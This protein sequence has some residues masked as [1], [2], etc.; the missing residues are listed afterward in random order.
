MATAQEVTYQLSAK[1]QEQLGFVQGT[2]FY[3]PFPF[4]GMNVSASA[5]AID[6]KE[7]RFLEN[8]IR[9]GDGNFRTAWDIGAAVYTSPTAGNLLCFFWFNI[10]AVTYCAIFFKDGTAIQLN[11]ATG[12]VTTI[13]SVVGTF[14]TSGSP[15]P[16]CCQSG[17][18]YL[19]IANNITQNSYWIWDGSVLY[20]AGSISPKITIN[21]GGNGYSSI[22][23]VTAFG[24]RGSGLTVTPVIS[25]GSVVA[26]NVTNPGTGYLPGDFVQFAF[27]GGGSDTSAI[28]QANLG[29]NTIG[30]IDLLAGGSGFT[31]GTFAL[32]IT[33]GGGVGATATYTT[34][35]GAVTTITLT[36]QGTGYTSSPTISFPG[37]GG[38]GAQASAFLSQG[39]VSSV[40][41]IDGGTNFSG[42]PSLSLIGGN[43]SGATAIANI[44]A[45]VIVSVTITNGG[46]GYT[47][48]PGVQV[49]PGVNDAASAF[50]DL[51]PFGVS[52]SS[53][54]TFQSRVWLPFPNHQGPQQ[55]GGT[56][57]VSAPGSLTDFAP[58]DGGLIFTSSDR[59]LRAQYV[60]IR[61]SN[62]YLYP[63]GDSSVSVISN[64]NT[65]GSPSTTTFNYQNVD[66]QV[67]ASWRDSCQDFSTTILFA[68]P[69]GVFGIYG[70]RAVKVS[71]KL[72]DL[73]LNAVFPPNA[74]AVI[75]SSATA[76]LFNVKH[77]LLLMTIIDPFTNA[78][79]TV[80]VAWNEAE[81]YVVSQSTTLT[82]IGSQEISSNLMAWG[83]DGTHLYPLFAQPSSSLV[84]IMQSKLYGGTTDFLFK[85]FLG[86][87]LQAQDKS[88]AKVGVSCLVNV[89][90]A[91][92]AV[93]PTDPELVSVPSTTVQSA[94]FV[95]P[96]FPAPQP[97]W[98]VF[99][100]GTG[101][102]PFLNLGFT[103]SSTAPDFSLANVIISYHDLAAFQ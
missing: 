88:T 36:A 86:F 103:L 39:S 54:E 13:S 90:V 26:L 35:G 29:A 64:V 97:F 96:S 69:L 11:Q 89:D 38:T 40:T 27:S 5:P 48:A 42:T 78:P 62:G 91:G 9:V 12:V 46:S 63:L 95:Q 4:G 60:N 28:L 101:G 71:K 37:G 6:D 102:V 57:F 67:G 33:G 44:S 55:N 17:S 32:G 73:F 61:Q 80:M 79:R 20:G 24:G 70:G 52:G 23:T 81:W 98:P 56:F 53:I 31:N 19:L 58:S 83:T 3:S 65:S 14:Y 77:Y 50:A 49:Q 51:M 93:Q 100:T 82:Y 1:A 18:Q 74:N 16:A 94:L 66:P 68:N 92:M 25:N 8:F 85:N 75:P 2:K 21:S 76:S 72:D 34:S 84:K 30:H 22:P 15:S 41:V 87:Y 7:F 43:G 47:I 59:F 10:G 99:G 45:G